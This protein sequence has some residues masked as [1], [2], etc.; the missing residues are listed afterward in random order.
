M[1]AFICSLAIPSHAST[2][3]IITSLE[4][5]V[6]VSYSFTSNENIIKPEVD[7]SLEG[8]QFN[9]TMGVL[10]GFGIERYKVLTADSTDSD[11]KYLINTNMNNIYLCLPIG[12]LL[13]QGFLVRLGL[14]EGTFDIECENAYCKTNLSKT[15]RGELKQKIGQIHFLLNETIGFFLGYSQI[16]GST[17]V[18]YKGSREKID[19]SGSLYSIGLSVLFL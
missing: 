2:P 16:S 18:I 8:Y 5:G 6:P 1:T 10:F 13:T 7:E 14:G 3:R 12:L 15:S 4:I 11:L 17:G 9:I 19:I